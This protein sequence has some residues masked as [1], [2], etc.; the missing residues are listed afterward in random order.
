M[1]NTIASFIH[2]VDLT[3]LYIFQSEPLELNLLLFDGNNPDHS[4]SSR[5][6][7]FNPQ[8]GGPSN[9]QAGEPSNP[10]G[11]N[12][13][14]GNPAQEPL[15][16]AMSSDDDHGYKSDSTDQGRV[17]VN[18]DNPF[19][20]R[21]TAVD[22]I[23]EAELRRLAE[24]S[25]EHCR[26]MNTD[27]ERIKREFESFRGELEEKHG[28]PVEIEQYLRED[29]ARLQ[30]DHQDYVNEIARRKAEGLIS[31]SPPREYDTRN[32]YV[33]D[34][35]AESSNNTANLEPSANPTN[36]SEDDENG[37]SSRPGF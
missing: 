1:K 24:I 28:R 8:A 9:S 13:E 29:L 30:E 15:E 35:A 20:H 36:S 7:R 33:E 37:S 31:N 18:A 32:R 27:D 23:P 22:Q 14:S 34:T 25:A 3:S 10:Q 4:G 26:N 17:T 11:N 12:L 5:D 16:D 2:L 6:D 21:T 19:Q